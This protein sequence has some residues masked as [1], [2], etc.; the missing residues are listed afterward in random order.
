MG[1]IIK[2]HHYSQ[3][4]FGNLLGNLLSSPHRGAGAPRASVHSPRASH[5]G[6]SD[7]L[8]KKVSKSKKTL[9]PSPIMKKVTT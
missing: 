7:S 9:K 5:P 2:L 4:F 8:P 6:C 1:F 3:L